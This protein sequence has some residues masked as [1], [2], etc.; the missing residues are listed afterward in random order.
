MI[1]TAKYCSMKC[2]GDSARQR[3]KKPCEICNKEFEFIATRIDKAKYCSSKCY[4]KSQIGKGTTE[5][6]CKFCNKKF[7]SY[8]RLGRKYCSRPCTGKGN[9]AV[10][11]P[12]FSTVRKQMIKRNMIK[13]CEKCGYNKV[14]KILGVHHIDR[15]RDNNNKDNLIVLCPMCHSLEHLKHIAH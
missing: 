13:Q 12:K 5:Y 1:S 3:F 4:H 7:N 14:P 6:S 2:R 10:W 8:K 15:N 9:S 11:R